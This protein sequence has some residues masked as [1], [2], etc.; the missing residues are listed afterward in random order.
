VTTLLQ[1]DRLVARISL[2]RQ[3]LES[4]THEVGVAG[5]LQVRD[6]ATIAATAA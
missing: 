3:L 1:F 4:N 6:L 2:Q 5:S